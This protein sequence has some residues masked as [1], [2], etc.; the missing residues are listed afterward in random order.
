MSKISCKNKYFQISFHSQKKENEKE[1][2]RE[3]HFNFSSKQ[4]SIAESYRQ[5]E[6]E[7]F[8]I[9]FMRWNAVKLQ[10]VYY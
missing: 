7:N 3:K 5:L 9:F 8:V 6:G 10:K 4:K 1:R 2:K